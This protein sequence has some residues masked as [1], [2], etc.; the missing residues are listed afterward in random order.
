MS[1]AT[2][3]V[4]WSESSSQI[5]LVSLDSGF[6]SSRIG[7]RLHERRCPSCN[8]IVYTR[9]HNRCGV[10]ERILPTTCLFNAAEAEKVEV[11]IRKER[12]RHR[13]WLLRIEAG[14]Q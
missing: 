8:A 11:V 10:C 7:V 9:R 5:P 3:D 2:L 6:L 13:A 12:Q 1:R 14:G 4:R